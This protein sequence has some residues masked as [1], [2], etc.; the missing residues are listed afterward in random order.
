VS[1]R[2][3]GDPDADAQNKLWCGV[4][5]G[6][7]DRAEP[8]WIGLRGT[9]RTR[10]QGDQAGILLAAEGIKVADDETVGVG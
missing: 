2:A 10:K 1:S 4:E 6:E 8:D 9:T 3:D 5:A 7:D